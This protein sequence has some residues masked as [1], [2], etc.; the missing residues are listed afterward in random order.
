[1]FQQWSLQHH[2]KNELVARQHTPGQLLSGRHVPGCP[3]CQCWN[4]VCL[5]RL[6]FKALPSFAAF[7]SFIIDVPSLAA[8]ILRLT[9]LKKKPSLLGNVFQMN[10][11][12]EKVCKIELTCCSGHDF[13]LF[14]FS[15]LIIQRSRAWQTWL[16]RNWSVWCTHSFD[17]QK[18]FNIFVW[19]RDFITIRKRLCWLEKKVLGHHE[20]FWIVYYFYYYLS[21]TIVGKQYVIF[22]SRGE[23]GM[24]VYSDNI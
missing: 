16:K 1:M 22:T 11:F 5:I 4:S 7:L 21:D 13:C 20:I 18:G 12:N 2:I 6:C 17:T 19:V 23:A 24:F 3:G 10:F 15:F 9:S 14:I 8:S